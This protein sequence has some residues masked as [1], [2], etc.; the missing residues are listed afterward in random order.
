LPDETGSSPAAAPLGFAAALGRR[1][2]PAFPRGPF[3]NNGAK[4]PDC[5]ANSASFF[6][7]GNRQLIGS[8]HSTLNGPRPAPV[9]SRV[10]LLRRSPFLP[11]PPCSSFMNVYVLR[12]LLLINFGRM[13]GF[14]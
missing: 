3:N 7:D 2:S 1:F 9:I 14:H 5:N 10:L 6:P 4:K 13:R 12:L 11:V 8:I